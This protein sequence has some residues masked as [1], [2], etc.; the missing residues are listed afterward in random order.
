MNEMTL[1]IMGLSCMFT[2]KERADLIS[3]RSCF[4]T[5]YENKKLMREHGEETNDDIPDFPWNR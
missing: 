2:D 4:K 5:K 3:G 1:S